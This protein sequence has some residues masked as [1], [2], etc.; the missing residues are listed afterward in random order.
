MSG[1]FFV[2]T[3]ITEVARIRKSAEK[4][5]FVERVYSPEER[6][7]FSA[8]R[9][10]AESMAANWAAKEAFSKALGT[11]V[12]G[13]ELYEVACLR[14]ELGQPFFRLSGKAAEIVRERGLELSVSL[15]HTK[16]YATAVVIAY[17][18]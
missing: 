9:D 1:R 7:L 3:D 8:K 16:E 13:F 2:G 17:A 6:A 11:G 10:P 18:G 15:S 14:D 4:Q 5:R 12:R